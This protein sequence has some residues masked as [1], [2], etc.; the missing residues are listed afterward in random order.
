VT[1]PAANSLFAHTSRP[2]SRCRNPERQA[3]SRK[4]MARYPCLRR[5]PAQRLLADVG[6]PQSTVRTCPL[7]PKRS[8]H[9]START[10]GLHR[11]ATSTP[12]E[13]S[14]LRHNLDVIVKSLAPDSCKWNPS[15]LDLSRPVPFLLKTKRIA[16]PNATVR[17]WSRSCFS[18]Q[19][20]FRGDQL[21][22]EFEIVW[23]NNHQ[24]A[25]VQSSVRRDS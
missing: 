6:L 23:L 16:H 19:R 10:K 20:K 3:R 12:C 9:L 17:R 13:N 21:K 7:H 22:G 15:I 4:Q 5:Y 11:Q 18:S 2:L 25:I 1:V 8:T 24:T 14:K